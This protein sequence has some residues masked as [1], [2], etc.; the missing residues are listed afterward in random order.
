MESRRRPPPR[1][2]VGDELRPP[3]DRGIEARRAALRLLLDL[4]RKQAGD[5]DSMFR[6]ELLEDYLAEKADRNQAYA[7]MMIAMEDLAY[8][9]GSLIAAAKGQSATEFFQE[10]IIK[11]HPD[12]PHEGLEGET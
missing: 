4:S 3:D 2:A 7:D 8:S 5:A 1:V 11:S 12:H 10:L 6:M 9:F